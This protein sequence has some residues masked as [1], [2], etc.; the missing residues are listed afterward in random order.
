MAAL[1]P[2]GWHSQSRGRSRFRPSSSPVLLCRKRQRVVDVQEDLNVAFRREQDLED[3]V[4]EEAPAPSLMRRQLEDVSAKRRRLVQEGTLLAESERFAEALLRWEEALVFCED[5][6]EKAPILE[7]MAQVLL[8]MQRD[9]DAV[10]TAQ[11]A[12]ECRPL[13]HC[14][15]LTLGRALMNFGELARAVEAMRR[16]AELGPA[17]KEAAEELRDAE[18]M[19]SQAQERATVDASREV[20][21]NGRVVVPRFWETALRVTYDEHG[22]PT[23]HYPV[24]PAEQGR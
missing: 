2:F 1:E 9:F 15:H 5:S 13:W 16:A 24:D 11:L 19:L 18:R 14:G 23:T 6:M 4:F 7:Q 10:R 8:A 21:V 20:V 22:M 3:E 12:I 17:D